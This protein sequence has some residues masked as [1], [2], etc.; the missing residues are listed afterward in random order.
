MTT[1]TTAY[2]RIN[3]EGGE[4][5]NPHRAAAEDAEAKWEQEWNKTPAGR[6]ESAN[7][8]VRILSGS[9]YA[10][11]GISTVDDLATAR[12]EVVAIEAEIDAAFFAEWTEE[13]F[14]ARRAA[15]NAEKA[16]V[17]TFMATQEKLGFTF[18]ELTRA[19]KHYI[20]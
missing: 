5:Y 20:S 12:A 18:D 16:T 11:N 10:D 15:W 14:T 8:K 4:G 9:V 19:K 3:N 17:K 6:L 1:K 13:V 2:D 7:R